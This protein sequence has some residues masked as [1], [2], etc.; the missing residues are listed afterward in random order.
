MLNFI[1]YLFICVLGIVFSQ[2][3]WAQTRQ[4]P[5]QYINLFDQDAVTEML[6]SGVPASITLAQ[7]MLESDYGN[8]KLAKQAKNHFGIKCHSS[9]KGK[10]Y[11]MD[12]DAKHECFRV[13]SSVYQSYVDHSDFL[14]RNQRYA[15]LFSLKRTDYKGWA[16]GLKKAG[17]ATNPKYPDLLIRIIEENGLAKF[18]KMTKADLKK[19]GPS[20]K[21]KNATYESKPVGNSIKGE[22]T[23][24]PKSSAKGTGILVSKNNIKFVYAQ[25]GDTPKEIADR[26][27]L[28]HWQILRYNEVKRNSKIPAG[29]PIY[30]Q[31]KKSKF[32]PG[33]NHIVK[34]GETLWSIS[35]S[36][37]VKI[38]KLAKRNNLE[39]PSAIT[40]GQ[41]LKLK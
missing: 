36:Y 33:G 16:K 21:G 18:D 31:P 2:S 41:K 37:G 7:G 14:K 22:N 28:G 1:K 10:G 8:S 12:D 5:S 30:L 26:Y 32:K 15:F 9:W 25:S 11:Y 23:T 38:K 4:T 34:K 29:T 17:Y 39:N 20:N 6:R 40:I 27:D 24:K 19:L 13:Y 3:I 35:Q